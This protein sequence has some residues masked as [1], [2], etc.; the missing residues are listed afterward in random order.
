[1]ASQIIHLTDSGVPVCEGEIRLF[2]NGQPAAIRAHET[3]L[4]DVAGVRART[5]A[6]DAVIL[7]DHHRHRNAA[8]SFHPDIGHGEDADIIVTLPVSLS[9]FLQAS[10]TPPF[11]RDEEKLSL[12]YASPGTDP[13]GPD[14]GIVYN[15]G[16]RQMTLLFTALSV[17]VRRVAEGLGVVLTGT[18]MSGEGKTSTKDSAGK[19]RK[20]REKKTEPSE[21]GT[22]HLEAEFLIP[23]ETLLF[24]YAG[25]TSQIIRRP[26]LRRPYAG[27][28]VQTDLMTMNLGHPL[29]SNT[30]GTFALS[31][32]GVHS[33]RIDPDG[34]RIQPVTLSG[35]GWGSTYQN[36]T[37]NGRFE[38]FLPWL[39]KSLVGEVMRSMKRI[40]NNKWIASIN[41]KDGD[42]GRY[43]DD[44]SDA[45]LKDHATALN[46][47]NITAANVTLS[48]DQYGLTLALIATLNDPD[49]GTVDPDSPSPQGNDYRK[50]LLVPWEVLILRDFGFTDYVRTAAQ[51]ET[52]SNGR[53]PKTT[54][55]GEDGGVALRTLSAIGSRAPLHIR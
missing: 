10:V 23:S 43:C 20:K 4:F 41:R 13:R 27:D 39:T 44:C 18:A 37:P 14:G 26:G 48:L 31:R 34:T 19:S 54:L 11:V 28:E 1:M 5:N 29:V 38:I 12:S 42:L 53:R 9:R 15:T 36:E 17:S 24:R 7:S 51:P 55:P 33:V 3:I 45:Y 16:G 21:R 35:W 22:Y 47:R 46:T 32:E 50:T 6:H 52:A 40:E 49:P 8:S 2:L 30:G 25:K